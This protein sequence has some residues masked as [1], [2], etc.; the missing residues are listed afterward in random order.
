MHGPFPLGNSPRRSGGEN[1]FTDH[2]Y[3]TSSSNGT[4][5]LG[6]HLI[7][8]PLC[9]FSSFPSQNAGSAAHQFDS[10]LEQQSVT[11]LQMAVPKQNG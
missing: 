1:T 5:A 3:S 2:S 11:A 10:L 6:Y 7:S 9:K 8:K 4:R